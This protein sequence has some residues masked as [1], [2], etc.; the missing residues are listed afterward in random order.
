MAWFRYYHCVVVSVTIIWVISSHQNSGNT[1]CFILFKFSLYWRH[2]LCC[3]DPLW[4][5]DISMFVET[6]TKWHVFG[7]INAM[8]NFHIKA[9]CCVNCTTTLIILPDLGLL[10][11]CIFICDNQFAIDKS[12]SSTPPNRYGPCAWNG[13]WW[14]IDAVHFAISLIG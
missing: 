5:I 14:Q 11:R 2:C 13:S 7:H 6:S 12:P 10:F 9:V 4:I 8:C 1:P 3:M